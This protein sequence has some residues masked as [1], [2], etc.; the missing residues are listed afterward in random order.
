MSAG[1]DVLWAD[2]AG[3]TALHRLCMSASSLS[4]VCLLIAARPQTVHARDVRGRTPLHVAATARRGDVDPAEL[5]ERLLAAGA[6]ASARDIDGRSA[7]DLARAEGSKPA[8]I[9]AL[10][11]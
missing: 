7:L 10:G 2:E 3:A 6:D 9:Q 8:V 5:I 1:A 4:H 11:G